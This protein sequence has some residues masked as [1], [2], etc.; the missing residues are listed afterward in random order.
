MLSLTFTYSAPEGNL[1]GGHVQLSRVYNTGEAEP[2]T[3]PIPAEATIS[4]TTSGQ[5]RVGGCPPYND[6]TGSTE[7]VWLYDSSNRASNRL[8]VSV[9]RPAG[10]P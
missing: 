9:T 2:H 5:I 1:Q 8:T 6:A 10:A 7:T 4:G 3:F